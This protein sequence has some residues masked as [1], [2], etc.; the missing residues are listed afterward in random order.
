MNLLVVD[1]EAPIRDSL[2]IALTQQGHQVITASGSTEAIYVVQMG[3]IDIA[4]IDLKMPGEDGI[5][6]IRKLN[7]LP[8]APEM[9]LMS[10][11]GSKEDIVEVM[12]LG[13][14]DFLQKPFTI[15]DVVRAI[16]RTR[17]YLVIKEKL[18]QSVAKFNTS[19]DIFQNEFEFPIIG[20]SQAIEQVKELIKKVANTPDTCVMITGESG[21]GKEN[22]ARGI[23][24]LSSRHKELFGAVNSSAITDSLFESEFFGYKKG[25]FT[26]AYENKPGW[27]E[28]CN[29]GTLFLDEITDLSLGNQ[30]K[31]LRTLEDKTI[32]RV[33]T[34]KTIELDIRIISA[35]NQAIDQMVENKQF[36]S[37]LYHRLN[38]FCIHIPPLRERKED[39]PLLFDFFLNKLKNK[40]K[41]N[42]KGYDPM[43]IPHL[44]AYA[45]PG[46]IRELKNI[47]ER[48][49]IIGETDYLQLR[50]IAPK[51]KTEAR[52]PKTVSLDLESIE[53]ETILKAI[54]L[55]GGKRNK[56]AQLL[57]ITPQ[58]LDRRL[59]KHGIK[60]KI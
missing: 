6:L 40:L 15:P 23:H 59:E 26:G 19:Q 31:L 41:K 27:F 48:A 28:V 20:N 53:K 51:A 30:A 45:Y 35:T 5:S 8:N 55:S 60:I 42:I 32:T 34:S 11:F 2:K 57:N 58:S 7:Q 52:Q 3:E 4:F 17:K 12:R 49:L 24:K 1:N 16:E 47:I 29:G 46:N 38:T 50:D 9:I 22:V 54:E 14:D 37:D 36:R 33:G 21:V 10:G 18:S 25:A 44:Q 56:T 43:I 13:V 39:I